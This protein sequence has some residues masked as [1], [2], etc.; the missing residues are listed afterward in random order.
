MCV[1]GANLVKFS[2]VVKEGGS[3]GYKNGWVSL[4][5]YLFI[6]FFPYSFTFTLFDFFLFYKKFIPGFATSSVVMGL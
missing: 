6:C 2:K 5:N 3:K 1:V 4:Q